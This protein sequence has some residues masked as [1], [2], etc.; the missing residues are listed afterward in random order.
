MFPLEPDTE[1]GLWLLVLV[2]IEGRGLAE[3]VDE[4]SLV[5][6]LTC[7]FGGLLVFALVSERLGVATV[8]ATWTGAFMSPT[9][10]DGSGD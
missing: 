7:G 8:L 4:A 2:S 10:L 6:T 1:N 5:T 3:D 9:A